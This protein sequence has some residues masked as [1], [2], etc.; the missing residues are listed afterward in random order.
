MHPSAIREGKIE[1]I[2]EVD[3]MLDVGVERLCDI[4][5]T[6]EIMIASRSNYSLVKKGEKLAGL[7]VIPLI[8]S[9]AKMEEVKP[10]SYTLLLPFWP[11]N[12]KNENI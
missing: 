4:N 8:V 1:V 6:E 5:E 11:M 2:G 7:R 10:V 12:K 3:G 9:K